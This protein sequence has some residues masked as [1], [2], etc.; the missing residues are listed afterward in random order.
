[1]AS[2]GNP[3]S[4]NQTTAVLA[5]ILQRLADGGADPLPQVRELV[6]ALQPRHR[7]NQ[8]DGLHRLDSL[9]TLLE[10][11]APYRRAL[12]GALFGMLA[13]S[14]QRSFYTET[15]LL[16]N[17]GFFSELRQIIGRRLLP[18]PPE[19]TTFLG[20]LRVVFAGRKTRLWLEW[21]PQEKRE[22]FWRLLAGERI[23][24]VENHQRIRAQLLDAALVIAHRIAAMGLEPEFLRNAPR[25][26]QGDSPFVA[27][28]DEVTGIA[29]K[30]RSVT[31][32][33]IQDEMDERHLQVLFD[34][35]RKAVERVHQAAASRGT[36]FPL[37]FLLVRLQQH[38]DR[39][40]L[41]LSLTTDPVGT[42]LRQAPVGNW[43]LL[44]EG[45][46]VKE[47]E[48]N[49]LH[50]HAANLTALVALRVTENA[51][52]TGEHY[53]AKDRKEWTG[54]WRAAAGAGFLIAF[55]ALLKISGAGFKLAVLNQGLFNGCIYA[56]G[57]III[58]L[59][60]G[61]VATKQPAMTAAT[62]AATVSQSRGRLRDVDQLASLVVATVRSQCAAIAG[63]VMV[64]LPLATAVALAFQMQFERALV[65][66][67]KAVTL[68]NELTP[69]SGAPIYAAIAGLW[70]FTAGLVSGLVDNQTAY[71]QLGP[72]VANLPWLRAL[73]GGG[74]AERVGSYLDHNAGG[75][76]GN[77][78]FGMMLGLTP[79]LGQAFGLPLDIRHI[80]FSSANFGYALIALDFAVEPLVILRCLCGIALIG[81]INLA[82][83]F[84]LALWVALRSRNVNFSAAAT[85]LPELKK[86]LF[87]KPSRFFLPPR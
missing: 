11:E 71:G 20:R 33:A 15:G 80:A 32:A 64:A 87:S 58:H 27:L 36:S 73:L 24:S 19:T 63:N 31:A 79:A 37:T 22:T 86:R 43:S 76:A 57:F 42:D 59:C 77:L 75:L 39:L 28:C 38:L 2:S 5:S 26:S 7:R 30:L 53:I 34:Q 72:R 40:E 1:M 3:A 67:A 81:A 8:A 55:M 51:G 66:P 25:L 69:L 44:I 18:D 45:S 41:L 62:I 82:V 70:L 74:R 10:S 48:R 35:C 12:A 54:M 29:A 49:N 50:R 85:L 17:T 21:L 83:S 16:P 46:I 56:G 65:A 68:L 84:S 14:D 52:R 6:V 9:L 4:K 47:L 61:T 60:R 78:F 13:E 23:G